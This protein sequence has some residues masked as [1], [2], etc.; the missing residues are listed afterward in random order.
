MVCSLLHYDS[1]DFGRKNVNDINHF[2][3]AKQFIK[4]SY[5]NPNEILMWTWIHTC[6]HTVF[7]PIIIIIITIILFLNSSVSKVHGS[8][9]SLLEMSLTFSNWQTMT[10]II[11]ANRKLF[12][13]LSLNFFL[14]YARHFN[15]SR[16]LSLGHS[17]CAVTFKLWNFYDN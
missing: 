16:G 4:L 6:Q 9:F 12:K 3:Q 2:P 8:E 11:Q 13:T 14:K 5:I 1:H 17:C 10:L 15:D 7:L